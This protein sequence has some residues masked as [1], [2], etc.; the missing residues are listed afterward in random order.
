MTAMDLSPDRK[1]E[2]LTTEEIDHI[3]LG[4]INTTDCRF[5]VDNG[6]YV[7]TGPR[8]EKLWCSPRI[9]VLDVW[10]S[11]QALQRAA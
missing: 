10:D 4:L 5:N 11:A 8:G 3:D 6:A 1:L 9:T 7:I 2:T